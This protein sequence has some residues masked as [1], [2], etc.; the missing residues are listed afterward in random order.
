M[1][2]DTIIILQDYKSH[3]G[4]KYTSVPYRSGMSKDMLRDE[5]ISKGYEVKFLEFSEVKFRDDWK[6]VIVLYTSQ[7]DFDYKYKSFIEDV[8]LGLELA[9]AIVL[10]G[11]S[12]LRAN[13][14]KVF[15]E[16]LRDVIPFEGLKGIQ[17]RGFGA[18]EE[19]ESSIDNI[20]FPVVIKTAGGAMS[21]GVSSAKSSSELMNQVKK[22]SRSFQPRSELR[23]FIRSKR[24]KGYIKESRF[25]NKFII[26]NMIPNL[27][28]DYKVLIYGTKYFFLRRDVKDNDF[29]ASGSGKFTF[30]TTYPTGMLDYAKAVFEAFNVPNISLDVCFDG[31][32]FHIIEFQ[33][34]NFGT[35]TI[36]KSP[37]YYLYEKNSFKLIHEPSNLEETFVF[38]ID[39]YLQERRRQ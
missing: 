31:S 25:R 11:Y 20:E 15:M 21:R 38:S 16:I 28:N 9:G 1:D 24:H 39:N 36:E 29:R 26:Q 32:N 37:F 13:N 7:E 5:F 17:S 22:I 3:F 18:I 2:K 27:T 10:P 4:S 14:N 6:D 19:I 34:L 23:D 8:I 30:E 35:T 12:L 33:A